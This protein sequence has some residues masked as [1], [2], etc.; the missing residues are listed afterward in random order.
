VM[1]LEGR[2]RLLAR[3]D[4]FACSACLASS[5]HTNGR[6][7]KRSERDLRVALLLGSPG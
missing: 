2:P 5:V 1:A 4:D 3:S 6:R 7:S